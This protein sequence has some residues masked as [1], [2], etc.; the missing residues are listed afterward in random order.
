AIAKVMWDNAN[1]YI[2]VEI[3]DTELNAV[4]NEN[5]N[6]SLYSDDCIEIF[7]DPDNDSGNNM[8]SDDYRYTVN[9]NENVLDGNGFTGWGWDGSIIRKVST[10]GTVNNNSD[11]DIR[12]T[13][14]VA[15]PWSDLEIT[16]VISKMFG[17]Q[18][19]ITDRDA[20]GGYEYFGWP[21]AN[22]SFNNPDG[23]A[24]VTLVG[25]SSQLTAAITLSDPTPTKAG[26]HTVTLV[27]STNVV[28]IPTPLIF[29]ES[30]GTTTTINLTGSVPGTVFTGTFVVDN[31]VA[32]GIGSF[33][34]LPGALEAELGNISNTI[35]SGA[36]V[37]IDKT[38]PVKPIGLTIKIEP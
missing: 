25:N 4:V 31:S 34:L 3:T 36:S 28:K 35:I 18:I 17:L 19:G 23:W 26:S 12:C 2:G 32:D 22:S 5:D 29:E 27:T 30:D 33:S 24:K 21:I 37:K 16:P 8:Q 38:A 20:V 1:L 9:L 13:I 15:I 11:I 14:E 7:I 10:D 6:T